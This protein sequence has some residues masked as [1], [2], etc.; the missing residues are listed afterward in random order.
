MDLQA[1]YNAIQEKENELR[2]REDALRKQNVDVDNGHPPNFPPFCPTV[3]HDIAVEIPIEMQWVVRIAFIGLFWMGALLI[4]NLIA[5]FTVGKFGH[6]AGET[7]IFAV[8][9]LI[10][11]VP[12][13]FKVN[14]FKLYTQCKNSAVTAGYL[15]LQLVY[16]AFNVMGAIG[17]KDSGMIG[18]IVMIDAISSQAGGFVKAIVIIS[19]VMW[20]LSALVQFFL[21]AK[22]L[23]LYKRTGQSSA[24]SPNTGYVPTQ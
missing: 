13:A 3:Y 8:I 12:L 5:A 22:S 19:A 9:F 17:L 23:I 14:Y 2:R 20:V 10:L 18:I 1:R 15:I 24:L 4:V 11:T 16:F 21:A 7:I 6:S